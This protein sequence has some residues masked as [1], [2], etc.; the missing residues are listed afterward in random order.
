M[1]TNEL[2]ALIYMKT[3]F[4]ETEALRDPQCLRGPRAQASPNDPL[5]MGL[6]DTE[7]W[8]FSLKTTRGIIKSLYFSAFPSVTVIIMVNKE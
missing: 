4:T 8:L 1:Y 7:S 2:T 6:T 5:W 3:F